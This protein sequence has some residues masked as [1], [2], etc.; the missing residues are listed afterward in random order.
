ML[1]VR[2]LEDVILTH[3]NEFIKK[4]KERDLDYDLAFELYEM[5]QA[6]VLNP[7]LNSDLMNKKEYFSDWNKFA[8]EVKYSV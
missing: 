4:N 2:L 6:D 7:H 8:K 1:R 5:R 3:N